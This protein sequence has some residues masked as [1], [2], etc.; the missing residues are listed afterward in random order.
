MDRL[1]KLRAIG[2]GLLVVGASTLSVG[3]GSSSARV[4]LL[5][6]APLESSLDMLVANKT[7]ASGV[8]YGTASSYASV[9]SGSPNLQI[10]ASGTTNALVNQTITVNS[11]SDNTVLATNSSSSVSAVVLT[12]NNAAPASGQIEI[13]VVNASATLG[14]ADIYILAPGTSISGVNPTVSSLAFGSATGYQPLTAGSYEVFFAPAGQKFVSIDSGSQ[15]FTTGQIR[16]IVG[17]DGQNGGFTS[18]VI[19]DLN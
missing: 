16:T 12:D 17:L 8:A 1:G 18:A 11:G 6:A 7:V 19:A 5:N 15:S 9:S 10:E 3:C 4:R 2:F 13:R 14:T